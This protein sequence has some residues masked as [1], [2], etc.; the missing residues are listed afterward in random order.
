[1]GAVFL[2]ARTMLLESLPP[3][4]DFVCD[5][6]RTARRTPGADRQTEC[7]AVM[8]VKKRQ[9]FVEIDVP[10]VFTPDE[11]LCVGDRPGWA[12]SLADLAP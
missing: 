1:M 12:L 3:S 11:L 2:L 6:R 5:A 7:A 10:L 8:L 9:T 4:G